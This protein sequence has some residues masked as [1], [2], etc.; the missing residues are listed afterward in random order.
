MIAPFLGRKPFTLEASIE[1]TN[2][3]EAFSKEI[4]F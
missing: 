1:A 3:K 4:Y 2:K